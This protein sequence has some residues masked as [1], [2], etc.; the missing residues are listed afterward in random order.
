LITRCIAQH[1]LGN[2]DIEE[3]DDRIDVDVGYLGAF[4]DDLTV[5]LTVGWNRDDNVA[6]NLGLAPEPVPFSEGPGA[7]VVEFHQVGI[8]DAADIEG[9][10]LGA[11][12]L[13]LAAAADATATTDCVEVCTK[14]ASGFENVG[15]AGYLTL[16]SRRGE[17][18]TGPDKSALSHDSFVRCADARD[19]RSPLAGDRS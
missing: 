13:D 1:W 3:T 8:R 17:D 4:A 19:P 18:D 11:S 9:D 5:D 12:E 15:A 6:Q 10:G 14:G 7:V 2:L 16:S